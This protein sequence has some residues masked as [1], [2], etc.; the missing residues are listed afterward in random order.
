MLGRLQHPGIAQVFSFQKGEGR[1]PAHVVMELVTGP[2]ITEYVQGHALGEA[3]GGVAAA[4]DEADAQGRAQAEGDAG[5]D[6]GQAQRAQD[7]AH[8]VED[9]PI[10]LDPRDGLLGEQGQDRQR[11]FPPEATVD[12][13]VGPVN[14]RVRLRPSESR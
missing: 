12:L 2:P 5:A 6:P 8:E 14:C 9:R 13:E 11:R 1:I 10:D 7:D 3:L 4:Q